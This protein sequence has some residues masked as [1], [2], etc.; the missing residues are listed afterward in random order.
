MRVVG[1]RKGELTRGAINRGW[2]FQVAVPADQCRGEHYR[3]IVHFCLSLSVASRHPGFS[4]GDEWWCVFCFAV[5]ADAEKFRGRFGGEKFDP[6]S[7]GRGHRWHLL[8]Q[9]KPPPKRRG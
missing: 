7:L 9:P 1:R 4:R 2:P 6:K 5:E 3:T 8:K